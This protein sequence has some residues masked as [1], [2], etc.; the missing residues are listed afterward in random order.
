MIPIYRCLLFLV[1]YAATCCTSYAQ[2]RLVAPVSING[3][4]CVID[5]NGHVLTDSIIHLDQGLSQQLYYGQKPFFSEGIFC[6][7]KQD[8]Y[9]IV[10]WHG[11]M[12]TS[13]IYSAVRR[14]SD[15]FTAVSTSRKW[16]MINSRGQL[17][18]DTIY[19]HLSELCNG[20]IAVRKDGFIGI[21]DTVGKKVLPFIYHVDVNLFGEPEFEDG[22]LRVMAGDTAIAYGRQTM[23]DDPVDLAK[24]KRWKIGFVNSSGVL[25]LDTIYMLNGTLRSSEEDWDYAVARGMVCGTG[26]MRHNRDNHATT[27]RVYGDYYRFRNGVC[28]VMGSSSGIVIDTTGRKLFELNTEHCEMK[29]VSGYFVIKD[30]HPWGRHLLAGPDLQEAEG[31]IVDRR[32]RNL[33]PIDDDEE[34]GVIENTGLIEIRRAFLTD[35]RLDLTFTRAKVFDSAGNHL[36]TYFTYWNR[37]FSESGKLLTEGAYTPSKHLGAIDISGKH[38][39]ATGT[40]LGEKVNSNLYIASKEQKYGLVNDRMSWVVKPFYDY[41][42]GFCN[43]I[44]VAKWNGKYGYIDEKGRV[45]IEAKYDEAMPFSVV[46]N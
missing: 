42:R 15:G 13:G 34:L 5:T 44:A 7:R 30:R 20:R 28:A 11:H 39:N 1:V 43:G 32:G 45:M 16:G 12:L 14:C 46:N 23:F 40:D 8:R 2:P 26:M 4:L 35:P 27:Y 21:L 9:T 19:D 38:W 25:V 24:L 22:L 33:L 36:F 37:T 17:I 6:F 29:N 3:N 41:L 31:Y 10:D 18:A